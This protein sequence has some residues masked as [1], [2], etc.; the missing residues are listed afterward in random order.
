MALKMCV[1]EVKVNFISNNLLSLCLNFKVSSQ[2]MAWKPTCLYVTFYFLTTNAVFNKS[3][4]N[5][6]AV[7]PVQT[8]KKRSKSFGYTKMDVT[9]W[10]GLTDI[11]HKCLQNKA[12]A[13]A[14][15]SLIVQHRFHLSQSISL[16]FFWFHFSEQQ[17]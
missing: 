11:F 1:K 13:W 10:H 4:D 5:N 3:S 16:E 8:G 14:I 17:T 9:I 12:V 7:N 2:Q 6:N 15:V